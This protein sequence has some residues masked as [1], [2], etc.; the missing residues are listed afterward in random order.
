MNI[1]ERWK[2][3]SENQT[4]NSPA[5]QSKAR[6][7]AE[8]VEQLTANATGENKEICPDMMATLRRDKL[9]K[10]V[11]FVGTGTCG[12]GAGPVRRWRKSRPG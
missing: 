3:M 12:L 1:A 5:L 7:V 6:P 10:P 11:I 8:L 2:Q 4:Q 9:D